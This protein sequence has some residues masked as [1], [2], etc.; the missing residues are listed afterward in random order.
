MLSMSDEN[1]E[2]W[3]K[4][5]HLSKEVGD[6]KILTA[7]H[8][9]VLEQHGQQ[10]H[11][12]NAESSERHGQILEMIGAIK[13][14]VK[15]LED[16]SHERKGSDRSSKYQIWLAVTLLGAVFTALNYFV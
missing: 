4:H 11:R 7:V 14:G 8:E 3:A 1:P 12:Y 15:D 16:D 13:N 9:K 5:D 6:L 10:F 2:L